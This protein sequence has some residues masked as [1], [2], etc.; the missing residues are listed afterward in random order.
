MTLPESEKQ[1]I[2]ATVRNITDVFRKE[3]NVEIS[4]I[5]NVDGSLTLTMGDEYVKVGICYTVQEFEEIGKFIMRN[6]PGDLALYFGIYWLK[7]KKKLKLVYSKEVRKKA[8]EIIDNYCP[9]LN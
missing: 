1:K 8:M 2:T 5:C 7:K 6:Y 3:F 4:T 9:D